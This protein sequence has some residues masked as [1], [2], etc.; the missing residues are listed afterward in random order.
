MTKKQFLTKVDELSDRTAEDIRVRA[1]KALKQG[2]VELDDWE[3]D[4]RLPKI[5]L[6]AIC[7][8]M[9][10][11]WRPHTPE[12]KAEVENIKCFI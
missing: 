2:C 4:Y 8:E 7:N 9:A 5:M 1:R 12:D 6:T 11:Q 3:N 10:W